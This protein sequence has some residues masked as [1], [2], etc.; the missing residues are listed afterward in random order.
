MAHAKATKDSIKKVDLQSNSISSQPE[1]KDDENL[2]ARL[3]ELERQEQLNEELQN[4]EHFDTDSTTCNSS[5]KEEGIHAE[6]MYKDSPICETLPVESKIHANSASNVSTYSDKEHAQNPS[7]VRENNRCTLVDKQNTHETKTHRSDQGEG[8]HVA[9]TCNVVK[10]NNL[11]NPGKKDLGK[12]VKWK[13]NIVEEECGERVA[14][15]KEEDATIYFTHSTEKAR[16]KS[17]IK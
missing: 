12:K 16:L 2:F 6:R 7:M 4:E 14:Y 5:W 3:D 10:A 9:D 1:L 11:Y 8:L 17:C 13:E 15:P